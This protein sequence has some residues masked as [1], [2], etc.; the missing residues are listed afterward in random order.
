[1]TP[2]IDPVLTRRLHARAGA[3][4]WGLDVETFAAALD[5]SA[6]KAFGS[7]APAAGEI[8]R[9]LGA[10]HLEDLA[11]AW[12]CA[13]GRDAAWDHFM[14]SHR[15]LLHR[16]ADSLDPS[17]RARELADALWA[18]LYGVRG[19]SDAPVSLLRSFH[20]RSSLATWLR[21]VLAQRHVDRYRATRRDRPL[22]DD[23]TPASLPAPAAPP[24]PE[25]ARYL[26]LMHQGLDRTVAALAPRERLRLR[27][28]YAEE[29]TLAET[30][31]ITG[32]HEAT[33]SRQLAR[34]RASIRTAVERFLAADAG[35]DAAQIAA[36]FA[37][38]AADAGPIDLGEILGERPGRKK[39]P[40]DRSQEERAR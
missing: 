1:V 9:F 12:A 29:L 21:A 6:R 24:D 16:A 37:S 14:S 5:A 2:V 4:R 40:P 32:E 31:R 28:Y 26:R 34:T 11:L 22:P 17:G 23:D 3:D 19:R 38:V 7:D 36:C 15:P 33:V 8:E 27:C 39:P 25:R 18:E 13:A 20:G 35:L 30:G 10:L